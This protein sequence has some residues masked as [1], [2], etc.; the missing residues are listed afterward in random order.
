[1][2]ISERLLLVDDDETALALMKDLLENRGFRVDCAPD[3]DRAEDLLRK[4]AYHAVTADLK[5]PGRS[6]I[7]LVHLCRREYPEIP[8]V[9]I[10]G[11]GSIRSAVEVLKAGAFDYLSKPVQMDELAM[12]IR[13]AVGSRR[14]ET[15]NTFLRGELERTLG[16]LYETANDDFR[17]IY[18]TVDMIKNEEASI[19][20]QGESGTGKEVIA[21]LIHNSGR[22]SSGSFVP[23][24]CGAIPE[25]LI[26]SELFGFE[27]GAFTGA[28]KRTSGKLEIA[29]GGTLF[30]DE[31]DE[32]PRKA[33]VAL[34][35]FIQEREIVPLGS[36]RRIS[37]NVRLIAATNR[38]LQSLVRQ[39]SFREDLYYRINVLPI[40][41]PPL[42]ERREDILP[43]SE[44][45]LKSVKAAAQRPAEGFSAAARAVLENYHWPG[46]M[47]ELRNV[48]DRA[49][50][51]CRGPLIEPEALL[52]PADTPQMSGRPAPAE[53][54]FEITDEPTLEEL[55]M[56]Y[57]HWMLDRRG[58]S[59][60][61]CA[62][63]LG[64]SVRGLRYKLNSPKE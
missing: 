58:G 59:R 27:R 39:G 64:I 1:M 37:V 16:C 7:D 48:V 62:E 35:R 3:A 20:L 9:V 13:K 28:E 33:Q 30:L 34:L 11:R 42:R 57:I 53:I 12:V 17:Q 49:A 25:G 44:W 55:E 51:I 31:I 24:N 8:V 61:R 36:T 29:D 45:F 14:L 41:L 22:R 47:R 15:Q 46:N 4:T 19:L 32:L 5:M 21:R 60:T 52:L 43:F 2:R 38:D 26:E 56:R 50:I 63:A 6:G 10:T 18:R 54:T 40:Y 23:I